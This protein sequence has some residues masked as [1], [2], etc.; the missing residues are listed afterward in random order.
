[1]RG[2]CDCSPE[3]VPRWKSQRKKG[4]GEKEGDN[5]TQTQKTNLVASLCAAAKAAAGLSLPPTIDPE[6]ILGMFLDFEL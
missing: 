5:R 2:I 6:S 3:K 1:M 4:S